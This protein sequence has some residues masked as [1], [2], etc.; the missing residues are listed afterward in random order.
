M[1]CL[2]GGAGAQAKPELFSKVDRV[3][4]EKEPA[5]K[6]EE[7]IPGDTS[8]PVRQRVIYRSRGGR[9]SVDIEIWRREEDAREVFTAETFAID[10]TAA[11]IS[12]TLGRE[13][14]NKVIKSSLRGLGDENHMWVYESYPRRVTV[15]FRKGNV[16]IR[17]D[18]TSEA[19]AKRFARHVFGQLPAG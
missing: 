18:S 1:L 19:V 3:L 2:P 4:R 5:W 15:Q 8:D 10:N 17:V 16:I 14:D 13:I 7:F 9:A 11:F 6:V 12:K